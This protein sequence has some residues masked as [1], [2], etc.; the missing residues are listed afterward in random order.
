MT[1]QIVALVSRMDAHQTKIRVEANHEE[2]TAATK[3][4][5]ERMEALMGV[6]IGAKEA[7]L[8]RK[9]PTERRW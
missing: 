5:Q 8:E 3:A 6:S 1:S 2:W 7:C 4:S 9:K